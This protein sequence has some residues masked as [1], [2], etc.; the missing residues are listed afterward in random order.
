MFRAISTI[1]FLVALAAGCGDLPTDVMEEGAGDF[2]ATEPLRCDSDGGI[3]IGQTRSGRLEHGD[4]ASHPGG[5]FDRWTLTLDRA[6][7]VRIDMTSGT[8][9]TVLELLDASGYGIA[10]NDDALGT[11]NSRIV[12]SLGPGTYAVIARTYQAGAGGAYELA[13][14]ESEGCG[15]GPH[16]IVLGVELGG[17]ITGDDCLLDHWAL[18]DSLSLTLTEDARI[19]FVVKSTDFRPL[20]IVRDEQRRDVLFAVDE[21][22]G[23]VAQGRATLG[24]GTYGVY[25]VSDGPALGSYQLLAEEVACEEPLPISMGETVEGTLDEGDCVRSGG[26]FRDVWALELDAERTVRVDLESADF[27][28]WVAVIDEEGR[29]VAVDDDSGPG[30]DASLLVT[31]PAGRYRILASSFGPGGVGSY[32]LMVAEETVATAIAAAAARDG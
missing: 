20:I 16:Q 7:D 8:F 19:D 4:C 13:V 15:E 17:E 29:E 6:A 32:T 14:E 12:T 5:W 24:A 25:V 26:A 10:Y 31:L 22:G 30:F 1:L 23:G 2:T 11:L 21:T 27:D 18:T 9:D 3:T 28:A